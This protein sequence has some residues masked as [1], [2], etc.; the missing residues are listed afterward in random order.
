MPNYYICFITSDQSVMMVTHSG[1]SNSQALRFPAQP[2]EMK[3]PPHLGKAEPSPSPVPTPLLEDR[4]L[5]KTAF[6]HGRH[7]DYLRN[8]RCPWELGNTTDGSRF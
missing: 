3:P 7:R 1:P 4:P 6:E 5:H 2:W 8:L